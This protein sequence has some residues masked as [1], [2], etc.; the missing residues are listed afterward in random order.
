[1]APGALQ[2]VDPV[3]IA[4]LAQGRVVVA[5][6]AH[7]I[8]KARK[9][10]T[11]PI[12]AGMVAPS[13]SDPRPDTLD[14][15]MLD[16]MIHVADHLFERRV[17][18]CAAVRADE[19]VA[20]LTPTMP[21]L[22]RMAASCLSRRLRE[23]RADRMRVGMGGDERRIRDLRDVPEALLVQM[24]EVDHDLALVA[25]ADQLTPEIG[26][27]RAGIR[28]GRDSGR[29][30]RVRRCSSGSRPARPIEVRSHTAHRA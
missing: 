29:G 14:A 27:A 17:A 30:R 9:S 6:L 28:T 22:S 3:L 24:R 4:E 16:Q 1:M 20:K 2:N 21:L 10:G 25:G 15:Q 19:E 18:R 5:V 13:K 26:Q 12:S 23:W 7:G 8:H 11:S